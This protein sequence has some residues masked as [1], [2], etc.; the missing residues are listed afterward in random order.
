MVVVAVNLETGQREIGT[1]T[2]LNGKHVTI[3][4]RD[5]ETVERHISFGRGEEE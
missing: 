1:V 5:G 3:T 4:L 2:E